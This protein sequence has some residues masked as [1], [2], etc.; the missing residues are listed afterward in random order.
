MQARL[1]RGA[2]EEPAHELL[3]P[4][5]FGVERRPVLFVLLELVLVPGAA[6]M[7][8]SEWEGGGR[9][10]LRRWWMVE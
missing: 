10:S 5:V 2:A 9:R 1:A 8:N 6:G 4:H 3:L 7:D